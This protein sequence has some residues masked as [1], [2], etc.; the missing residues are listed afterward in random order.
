MKNVLT[1]DN[2]LT[3][4]PEKE[5][6]DA[7]AARLIREDRAREDRVLVEEFGGLYEHTIDDGGWQ[8]YV[9]DG[10]TYSFVPSDS[11]P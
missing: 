2:Y 9:G 10:H 5:P 1:V 3:V 8:R 11:P 6:S 7:E 4:G